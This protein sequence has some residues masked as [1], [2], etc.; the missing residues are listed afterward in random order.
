MTA[1]KTAAKQVYISSSGDVY[2]VQVRRVGQVI[3]SRGEL[4]H[5]YQLPGQVRHATAQAYPCR[6]S[7]TMALAGA[8]GPLCPAANYARRRCFWSQSLHADA[9]M[10]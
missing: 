1:R 2:T 3:D 10:V 8:L 6:T 5:R 9:P 7:E 4:P